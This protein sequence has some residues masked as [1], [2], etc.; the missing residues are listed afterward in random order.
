[1]VGDTIGELSGRLLV[2]CRPGQAKNAARVASAHGTGLVLTGR[3]PRPTVEALRGHGFTGPILCDANRYS[4]R[5]RTAARAGVR[6]SWTAEQHDLGL[7]ALTD[8][9]YLAAHDWRGLHRVLSEAARQP[10]PV[11]AM[12]PL[13]ARWFEHSV[14][15]VV[16]ELDRYGV[17]VA[18]AIEHARDP[19][20][21][22]Y[23]VRG[24][25]EL[26]TASV[27]VLLLRSDVS[28]VG[29]LVHGAHAAAIG[30]TTHLRHV[31]PRPARTAAHLPALAAFVPPLMGHHPLDSLG[32][33]T[34]SW[35][36]DCHE[37]AGRPLTDLTSTPRPEVSAFRHSLSAQ[38]T[39]WSALRSGPTPV[40]D[41]HDRCHRALSAHRRL[42]AAVPGWYPP[43][44]LHTWTHLRRASAPRDEPARG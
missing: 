1:M 22:R 35:R 14:A 36:C 2:Q 4:G 31:P 34:P 20:G 9:G 18:V 33:L 29:A 19:F 6:G 23:L 5:R 27:P 8:S 44:N 24:F 16:A 17:P 38:L 7:V 42:S 32:R 43:A 3:M 26:L 30:T 13:A 37:C 21:V 11:V 15:G 25:L 10:G 40:E 39:L 41:W 12:L 28:A